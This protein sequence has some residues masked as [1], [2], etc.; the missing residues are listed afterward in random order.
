MAEVIHPEDELRVIDWNLLLETAMEMKNAGL[1]LSQACVSYVA[2]K[3]ELVYSFVNDET[4]KLTNV[5][6]IMET[7]DWIPSICAFYPYALFYENEMKELY[8]VDVRMMEGTDLNN[9]L[10]RIRETTPLLPK[11]KK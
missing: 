9:K 7:T 5:K 6:V 2:G 10:Y 11:E 3:Y 8:G 1:R 4:Y